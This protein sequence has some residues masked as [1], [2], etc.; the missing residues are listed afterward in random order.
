[1]SALE[2]ETSENHVP[3]PFIPVLEAPDLR[4]FW[5]RHGIRKLKTDTD[6]INKEWAKEYQRLDERIQTADNSIKKLS[7]VHDVSRKYWAIL[8]T[9]LVLLG[10]VN[11]MRVG[12]TVWRLYKRNRSRSGDNQ[13]QGSKRGQSL[14][15]THPREWEVS[16]WDAL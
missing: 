8:G 7:Q 2:L 13:K 6:D 1:M 3:D 12:T 5:L 10:A 9:T 16:K 15:R 11:L 14:R 4:I